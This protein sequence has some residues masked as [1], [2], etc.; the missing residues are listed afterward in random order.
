MANMLAFFGFG[1][2]GFWLLVLALIA[3]IIFYII[4][5]KVEQ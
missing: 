3:V 4:S 1:Q 2:L 5:R